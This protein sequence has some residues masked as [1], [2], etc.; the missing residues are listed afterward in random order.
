MNDSDKVA[1]W[2]PAVLMFARLSVWIVVPVLLAAILGKYLDRKFASEPWGLL[3]CVGTAFLFS[4]GMIVYEA[5][6]EY[7]KIEKNKKDSNN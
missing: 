1:W 5:G 3:F 4:M 6:K 2:Q 7:K